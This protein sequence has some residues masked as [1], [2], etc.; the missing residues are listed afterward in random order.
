M[1]ASATPAVARP[2]PPARLSFLHGRIVGS[3]SSPR[4]PSIPR[5]SPGRGTSFPRR[6]YPRNPAPPDSAR[7]RRLGGGSGHAG[8]PKLRLQPGPSCL[9]VACPIYGR[10]CGQGGIRVNVSESESGEAGRD[11]GSQG[12]CAPLPLATAG[13]WQDSAP[14]ASKA[15]HCS[16]P[17]QTTVPSLA[18]HGFL[19]SLLGF[20][21]IEV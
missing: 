4:R 1:W 11:A 8:L 6:R 13:V 7:Q 19:F 21:L 10:V 2:R 3:G 14:P 18:R 5:P 9:Q 15:A 20:T 17:P 12:Q 16:S